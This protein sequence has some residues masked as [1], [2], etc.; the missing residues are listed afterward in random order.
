MYIVQ[1]ILSAH[2]AYYNV[3]LFV[4]N[5]KYSYKA[6]M[7]RPQLT[8]VH[9]RAKLLPEHNFINSA[10]IRNSHSNLSSHHS[11]NMYICTCSTTH[12]D[13]M[14]SSTRLFSTAHFEPA[15]S[16]LSHQSIFLFRVSS[17]KSTSRPALKYEY[18]GNAKFSVLINKLHKIRL[19]NTIITP[20]FT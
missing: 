6:F 17:T 10:C 20:I 8:S 11:E 1:H 16:P 12:S 5:Y 18:Q 14:Y 19:V 2:I 15:T 13:H 4:N 9:V 3:S 7:S